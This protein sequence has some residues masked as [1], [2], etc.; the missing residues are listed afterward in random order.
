MALGAFAI[1]AHDATHWQRS[2]AIQELV[3][4]P[5][6]RD[7]LDIL[8][9]EYGERD[10]PPLPDH[11]TVEGTNEIIIPVSFVVDGALDRLIEKGK[12][13]DDAARDIVE[14]ANALMR[15]NHKTQHIIA[16]PVYFAYEGVIDTLHADID[17]VRSINADLIHDIAERIYP[18][19]GFVVYLS[20][21]HLIRTAPDASLAK[22]MRYQQVLPSG[23]KGALE[24]AGLARMDYEDD[25][26]SSR[27][28]L[29]DFT[30]DPTPLYLEG[31]RYDREHVC[32]TVHEFVHTCGFG[33]EDGPANI[34]ESRDFRGIRL[35]KKGARE[36]E[37]Y[38]SEHFLSQ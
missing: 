1:T 31:K 22:S 36:Y 32:T 23:A 37:R 16:H 6:P 3:F 28:A 5:S 25:F 35:M 10:L 30:S 13:P 26:A 33:H 4:L 14:G 19:R 12:H 29:V 9:E 7:S 27:T 2:H 21:H 15:F 8:V 18:P 38:V 34:M 11:R 24:I 17:T 20:G